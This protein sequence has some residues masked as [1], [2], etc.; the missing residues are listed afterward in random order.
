MSNNKP[1][2]DAIDKLLRA[3]GL[4]DKLDE[5]ELFNVYEE[6]AGKMITKHTK[7]IFFKQ[8][9]LYLQID[10]ATIKQE[11]LFN[12]QFLID[13][14]NMKIKRNILQDINIK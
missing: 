4:Q 5:V 14:I 2:K 13:S 3:Y 1:L 6:I 10:S 12:K 7:N 11:L 8:G 9:V